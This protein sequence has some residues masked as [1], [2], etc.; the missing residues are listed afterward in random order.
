M[1]TSIINNKLGRTVV[2]RA[3]GTNTVT[4]QLANLAISNTENVQTASVRRIAWSGNCMVSR[5]NNILFQYQTGTAGVLDLYSMGMVNEEFNTSNV[6]I[7]STD[8]T[9]FI[10]VEL[11]KNSIFPSVY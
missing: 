5:G 8:G 1:A 11:G 7:T 4:L 9:G 2:I 10:L 3:T 6:T